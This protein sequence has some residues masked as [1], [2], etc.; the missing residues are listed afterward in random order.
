MSSAV[1]TP[2]AAALND[3]LAEASAAARACL[4]PLGERAFLPQGVPQQAAEARGSSINGTIGQITT[5]ERAAIPLQSMARITGDL[6]ANAVFLYPPVGGFDAL[7]QAWRERLQRRGDVG[8]GLPVVTSGL[9]HALSLLGE[10]FAGPGHPLLLPSPCWGNYNHVFGTRR[11]APLR[12]WNVQSAD[13]LDLA[14]FDRALS[15]LDGPTVLVLNFPGNPTGY[16]PTRAEAAAVVDRLAKH[17]EPLVVICDD[18]YQDLVYEDGLIERSLFYDLV[19]CDNPMLIPVKVDGATKEL[20]FFGG[21]V[22]F[23][24]F[25]VGAEAAAVLE[26]KARGLVRWS[27]SVSPA[28]SQTLV[29]ACLADPDLEA[30]REALRHLMRARYLALKDALRQHGVPFR[31]F[32]S[33]LFAL[34]PVDGDPHR[35]RR[36]LLDEGL[37]V[38]ALPDA[39]ALRVSFGSVD[40]EDLPVLARALARHLGAE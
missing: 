13:G 32:N 37:G 31:P 4:S 28:I 23:V 24:T 15:T 18:A 10:L 40:A 38:V 39:G 25:G 26:D 3:R 33:G 17:D 2:T 11:D 14:D 19:A 30:E 29:L 8:S 5:R 20:S 9:T 6:D 35:I 7:R 27:V 21:R 16:T 12:H 22:G 34:V 1:P 36:A